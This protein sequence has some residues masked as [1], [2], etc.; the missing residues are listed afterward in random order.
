MKLTVQIKLLP[1]AEQSTALKTTIVMANSA[2]DRVSEMAW[3]T[4]EF[5]RFP[6]QKMT[7]KTIRDSFPLSSQIVCLLLGK[8]ADA[9]RLD[10]ECQRTFRPTGS[11]AFDS[12]V[13]K[14]SVEKMTVS[15]WSISGRLKMPFVCGERQKALLAFPHRESDLILRG[16]QWYL[17]VTVDVPEQKEQQAV[18][19]LGVDLGIVEI[20]YDSD[21]KNYSGS[22]LNKVR[23][24]NQS[25]RKK[26]ATQRNKIGEATSEETSIKRIE[27]RTKH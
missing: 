15:I 19:V 1:T 5:R 6:L 27:L 11:I 17:N 23:N 7:Y 25:L 13:L 12:R 14:I 2:A 8:V 21:G 22:H 26:T 9:Y 16:S 4:G 24:R 18:D 20:A 10:R 3:N